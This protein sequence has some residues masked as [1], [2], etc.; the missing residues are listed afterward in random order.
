METVDILFIDENRLFREGL[1]PMLVDTGFA[2]AGEAESADEAL[3]M[4]EAGMAPGIVLID[5][6]AAAACLSELPR[7]REIVPTVK[8]VILAASAEDVQS[9]A[10]CFEAGADAYLLKTISPDALVQSL[11]LVLMGE[12][13]FPTGL[14][15]LLVKVAGQRPHVASPDL[16][17]LSSRELQILRGLLSGHPNKVI[18]KALNITE[19][20]VKVH[21]KG[22]MRK[23]QT[24]NRTQA[25]I[26]AL[27]HGI[28][29]NNTGPPAIADQERRPH[30]G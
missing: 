8:L 4:L 5:F 25:A 20:T 18:A 28:A 17:A 16:D 3:S 24:A 1:K 2:V 21:L 6:E 19:A 13:V 23:I 29:T 26:W 11:N 7:F 27:N 15:A 22:V 10:F 9:L 30:S 14:A 12:S